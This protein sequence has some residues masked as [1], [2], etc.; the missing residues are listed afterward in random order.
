M[1]DEK[2]KSREKTIFSVLV[3]DDIE[4]NI[5][6]L[7]ETLSGEYDVRV[8]LDGES[9]LEAVEDDKPDLILLDIMMPGMDGYEVCERLKRE[10]RTRNIPIIFLTAMTEE[11]N[12]ARGLALGAV[13]YVTKPF[14]PDLVKSRVRNQLRLSRH[15]EMLAIEVARKTRALNEALLELQNASLDTI[16]RLTRAMEYRVNES[17][18]HNRRI[19]EYAAAIAN[20]LGLNAK[21]ISAITYAA[22]MHD[23]G[24]IGIPRDLLD[25]HPQLSP[26][27]LDTVK[28]HTVIGAEILS[29]PDKGFLQLARTIALTH[30]EKW[31]GSGYPKGLKGDAIPLAGRIVCLADKFDVLMSERPG[32]KAF[33]REQTQYIIRRQRGKHFDPDIV[34]AFFRAEAA[35]D[36]VMAQHG[37]G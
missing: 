4:A 27:E 9:A 28:N 10:P 13:D 34:D 3:V 18:H 35:M 30:H 15:R 6:I 22:P 24:K 17:G 23:V 14:S 12:E 5:D 29:G 25:R 8:A 37:T 1:T 26:E 16:M 21:T 19:S 36:T 31:D 33:S 32:R 7:V 20:E 11:K 2:K